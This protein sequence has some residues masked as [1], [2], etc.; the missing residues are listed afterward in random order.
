DRREALPIPWALIS[1]WEFHVCT[2]GAPLTTKLILG[3][4]LLAV[5]GCLRFGDLQRIDF[6][7][8]SLGRT[9]LH[10]ICYATKTTDKGQPFAVTLAGLTGRST[11]ASCWVLHWLH[12]M[13][14]AIDYMWSP[15]D[16]VDFVWLSTAPELNA[17]LELS[18]ASYCTAM[19][20][21]RW[22]ATLPWLPP[23]QGL[24][25]HEAAQLTLHSMKSTGLASA[26]QLRLWKEHRLTHGHHRDSAA[27]YSRNDVFASL[28]VQH[29]LSDSMC[30][31]WRAERSIARGGQDLLDPRW[32]FFVTR[33]EHLH[34]AAAAS[35]ETAAA[36]QPTSPDDIEDCTQDK[37][38]AGH[39]ASASQHDI[40]DPI[41]D[42]TDE[43]AAMVA[44]A[45]AL[46][47]DDTSSAESSVSSDHNPERRVPL[48][49]DGDQRFA[50]TG[51]WGKWHRVAMPQEGVPLRTA[52]GIRLGVAA[53]F[54][55]QP[56]GVTCRRKACA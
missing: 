49:I 11:T 52:C 29:S 51:P 16:V 32:V 21:L 24:T 53:Q 9:A 42:F 13:R 20:A 31:G 18:P 48:I 56:H 5:H 35:I 30:T 12:A 23:G 1:A 2:S 54:S 37:D 4:I 46:H 33:H 14:T 10:G 3:A 47:T 55:D 19:L 44:R 39:Q 38:A 45:A 25:A 41:E 28:D 7:S 15:G 22:A 6:E 40:G 26:A 17:I 27:L 34:A 43:E 50:C 36:P 8:L